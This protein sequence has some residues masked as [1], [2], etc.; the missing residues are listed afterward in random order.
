[1][2]EVKVHSAKPSA[3]DFGKR[4]QSLP[5]DDYVIKTRHGTLDLGGRTL[6]MGIINVTPD[7]F[8]DGGK[9]FDASKAIAD[10]LALIE[11]GA[12]IVDVGGES[13]RPG[14]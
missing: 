8:Y 5:A 13:T 3:N 6:L 12:D 10:G 4:L 11:A 1:M 14:A 7:S 2:S 9:R